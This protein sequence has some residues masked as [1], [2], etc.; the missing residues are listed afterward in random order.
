MMRNHRAHLAIGPR[1]MSSPLRAS[2]SVVLVL[3]TLGGP[4][5]AWADRVT[6]PTDGLAH[7]ALQPTL[8]FGRLDEGRV[9]L[10]DGMPETLEVSAVRYSLGLRAWPTHGIHV[11]VEQSLTS[12]SKPTA[13]RVEDLGGSRVGLADLHL[14]AGIVRRP[15]T[16]LIVGGGIDAT[17]PTG[18]DLHSREQ[19]DFLG[20]AL[21]GLS[22]TPKWDF[23]FQ[24][25]AGA[26]TSTIDDGEEGWRV[27]FRGGLTY[28]RARFFLHAY[29]FNQLHRESFSYV[30]TGGGYSLGLEVVRGLTISIDLEGG[31]PGNTDISYL[32]NTL[33][34]TYV[35]YP[36]RREQDLRIPDLRRGADWHWWPYWR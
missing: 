4:G 29:G 26:R 12:F 33:A 16:S 3:A 15:T 13:D 8:R 19:R 21:V 24:L 10:V 7:R 27:G 18:T 11:G 5:R 14:T 35:L 30:T 17:L 23:Y 20:N 2:C 9:F 31:L 1:N 6:S 32:N 25:L 22:F 34:L 28:Q 36:D